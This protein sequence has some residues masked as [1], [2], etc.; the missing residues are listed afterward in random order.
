MSQ[1]NS[2]GFRAFFDTALLVGATA[3]ALL[4]I[5]IVVGLFL[6]MRSLDQPPL[7]RAAKPRPAAPVKAPIIAPPVAEAP[8]PA[9]AVK[10]PP[11]QAVDRSAQRAAAPAPNQAAG[12]RPTY[13]PNSDAAKN[14]AIAQGLMQL[15]DDPE[16]QRKLAL[17]PEERNN[18]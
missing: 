18:Q 14:R 9:A 8:P 17:P 4:A 1:S 13:G 10:A 6:W 11:R 2:S 7:E 5:G 12:V 3:A 15:G 16:M